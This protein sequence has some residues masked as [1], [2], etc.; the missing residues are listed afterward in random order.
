[1]ADAGR[2]KMG[3][4][5]DINLENFATTKNPF[6]GIKSYLDTLNLSIGNLEGLLADPEELPYKPG[7]KHV[8]RGHAPNLAEAGFR[9]LNLANN[10]TFGAAAIECTLEQLDQAGIG[11]TGAGMTRMQARAPAIIAEEDVRIGIVSRTAVYWPYGHEATDE[12]AGVMPIRVAT[13]YRPL[14]RAIELPGLPPE[15]ITTPHADDLAALQ[16]DIAAVRDEVDVLI[17]FFHFGLSSRREVVDYQRTI[18]R[19]AIDAGADAVL[20]SHAHVIQPIE[21]YRD[22]PI[23]YGLGQVI[24][25]W[26]F[27]AQH[28]HPG[29]PGLLVELEIAPDNT[30]TWTGRLVK[31]ADNLEPRLISFAEAPDE[32]EHLMGSSADAVKLTDDRVIVNASGDRS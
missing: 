28:V 12:R 23:W 3:A 19:A 26:D 5:G 2:F 31:P 29:R 14:A 17:G 22:R 16:S 21:V 30:V 18:S 24:F 8:G 9:G 27:V 20:G 1:M 6:A 10:V 13:S 4:V 7:F 15:V 32:A 25:G 11:H